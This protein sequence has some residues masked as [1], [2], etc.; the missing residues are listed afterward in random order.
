MLKSISLAVLVVFCF[1]LEG[2]DEAIKLQ[3]SDQYKVIK[4][5]GQIIFQKT[6]T[7]M[8]Q[9]DVFVDGTPLEFGT[10]QSRAAV[11]S[12]VKGRFVISASNDGK[13]NVLPATNNVSSRAGAITNIVALKQQF[14]GRVLI[15]GE[16]RLKLVGESLIMNDSCFFYL[17]YLHNDEQIDK[18]LGYESQYL[19]LNKDEIFKIDGQPIEVSEKEMTMYYRKGSRTDRVGI[20]T[21]VFPDLES[22][23]MEV[24]IL[25]SE[26]FDKSDSDKKSEVKSYLNQ[27]YAKPESDNVSNWLKTEISLR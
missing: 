20:F 7:P 1:S 17:S 5:D 2:F 25:L 19:I 11:I 3:T 12:S 15:L 4:V 9:G 24:E 14:S 16:M 8:K 10:P 13:T 21:P 22:L 18:K 6:K 26:C 27:F 23:K